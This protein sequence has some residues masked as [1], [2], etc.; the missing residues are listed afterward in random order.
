MMTIKFNNVYLNASSTVVGPYEYKGPLGEYFDKHYDNLY[1]G[2]KTW[3]QAELKLM[4][5]SIELVL[6][7]GK[8]KP[9]NID[10]LVAGDLLNQIAVSDYSARTYQI[11]FLGVY[12]ACATSVEAMIIASSMIDSGKINTSICSVS[13]HNTA[14]EKQ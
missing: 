14:A 2:R 7:K 5:D 12:N 8:K 11:P 10:L 6:N 1:I 9:E 13:S 3:E 4:E